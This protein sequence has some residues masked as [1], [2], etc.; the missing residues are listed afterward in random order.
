MLKN[1]RLNI[2]TKLILSL[3]STNMLI[4]GLMFFVASRQFDQGFQNFLNQ[5]EI[6]KLEPLKQELALIFQQQKGWSWI[7]DNHRLWQKLIHYHLGINDLPRRRPP[8]PMGRNPREFEGRHPM[9]GRPP[10]TPPVFERFRPESF[11]GQIQSFGQTLNFNPHIALKDK[12][13]VIIIGP[14][15]NNDFLWTPIYQKN[16]LIGSLG[17]KPLRQF[18]SEIDQYF[19]SQ[20]KKIMAIMIFCLLLSAVLLALL[21]SNRILQQIQRLRRG[22]SLLVKGNFSE[23]LTNASNDEL[24]ELSERFNFLANTLESN[25][26]ARQQWIADISHELRTPIAILKGEIEALV[27]GVRPIN[28]SNMQSLQQEIERINLLINDLHELSLSDLGALNY[29]KHKIDLI[30]FFQEFYQDEQLRLET[31]GITVSFHTAVQSF[32]SLVDESRLEQ[33]LKNFTQNSLRY[34]DIPGQ[35]NVTIEQQAQYLVVNIEDSSPGVSDHDLPHLLD[36]LYRAEKSRNRAQGGAGLGLSIS[37]NILDAHDIAINLY[38]SKL[39]G[40]GITLKIPPDN[41]H[42]E[43]R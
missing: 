30:A 12:N 26:K 20:Q 40:L 37:K 8:P 36:R 4:A 28:Q 10:P 38:Q 34:T 24:G 18:N 35:V 23:R 31:K 16:Q 17:V 11:K 14:P 42:H 21:F 32:H 27:E 41:S 7:N 43:H 39:G 2:K 3:V 9:G 19:I 15:E 1:M 33:C 13:N 6:Q 5:Q 25:Q 29:Q 22:F